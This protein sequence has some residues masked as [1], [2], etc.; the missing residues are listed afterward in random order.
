MRAGVNRSRARGFT[1]IELLVVIAIIAILAAM[2]LPALAR[3]KSK[4]NLTNCINNQHQI[5]LALALY[6]DDSAQYYP[7]Y[8][9]WA[10]FGGQRGTNSGVSTEVS[11]NSLHGGNVD[12]ADRPL[13]TYTRNVAVYHCPADKGDSYWWAVVPKTCWDGWGNSYLIQW[14]T[15]SGVELVG[16]KQVPATRSATS[17]P[18]WS[19]I[20]SERVAL[21]PTTKLILGDWTWYAARPINDPRTVWHRE[22]GKRLFPI[23]FG[24]NHTQN[25]LFPPAYDQS[26]PTSVDINGPFW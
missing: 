16:G 25:F 6:G 19:P 20:K 8:Q 4:A 18:A 12:V 26:P 1:L 24:D 14:K 10:A 13:N 23:L 11:G 15:T 17:T 7:A 5:G 22:K 2:L 9:D 21:R 3:A